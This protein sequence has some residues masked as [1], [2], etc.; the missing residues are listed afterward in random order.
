MTLKELMAHVNDNVQNDR[1]AGYGLLSLGC[2]ESARTAA[3]IAW[4]NVEGYSLKSRTVVVNGHEVKAGLSELPEGWNSLF[5]VANTLS[6][7]F[8]HAERVNDYTLYSTKGYFERGLAFDNKEDA[9]AM[10]RAMLD[11]KTTD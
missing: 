9:I 1:P 6:D 3:Q 11:F 5:Y 2:V 10:A 8:Y 4:H 7:E